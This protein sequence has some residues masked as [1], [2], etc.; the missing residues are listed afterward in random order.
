VAVLRQVSDAEPAPLR[1]SRPDLPAWLVGI[2]HKLHAKDPT[3]RFQSAAEV[4]A[5]LEGCLAHVQQ[6]DSRPL[7]PLAAELGRPFQTPR[8]R[9]TPRLGG[10]ALAAV[11]AG[12][13]GCVA[14]FFLPRPGADEQAVARRSQAAA[15]AEPDGLL[16]SDEDLQAGM[17]QLQAQLEGWGKSVDLPP[18]EPP[19]W[20]SVLGEAR[21][22]AERLKRDL[23]PVAPDADPVEGQFESIRRRLDVVRQR[24]NHLVE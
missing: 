17:H 8:R 16:H 3:Q 21:R 13:L 23:G 24:M 14:L 22:R 1:A 12:V 19:G 11:T 18:G 15:P 10:R 6:P 9:P 7:L 2:I 4:A 20:D 5:L